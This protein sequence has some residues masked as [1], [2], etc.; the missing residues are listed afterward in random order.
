VVSLIN[1]LQGRLE[2]NENGLS[3]TDTKQ[4][5]ETDNPGEESGKVTHRLVRSQRGNH[6]CRWQKMIG[7]FLDNTDWITLTWSSRWSDWANGFQ[8]SSAIPHW[9]IRPYRKE[10]LIMDI[11]NKQQSTIASFPDDGDRKCLRNVGCLELMQL[12]TQ[13]FIKFSHHK[14]F[15]SYI[16]VWM[17]MFPS[18]S[19]S[20]C[21]SKCSHLTLFYIMMLQWDDCKEQVI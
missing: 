8:G 16:M 12:V 3:N 19:L 17:L 21:S 2:K 14:S 11:N 10:I 20:L 4:K 18:V 1:L 5:L 6:H 9:S 13:D 7:C 15:K